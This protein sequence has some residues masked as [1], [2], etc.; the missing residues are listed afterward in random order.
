M[1]TIEQKLDESQSANRALVSRIHRAETIAAAYQHGALNPEQ[2]ADILAARVPGET[3]SDSVAEFLARPE[4][5]NLIRD[6]NQPLDGEA[7]R[8]MSHDEYL[9]VRRDAPERLGLGPM[10]SSVSSNRQEVI[11][12]DDT[13]ND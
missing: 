9:R 3:A 7:L 6:P 11:I 2:V 8:G 13:D 1:K 12:H 5:E 4:N 10:G